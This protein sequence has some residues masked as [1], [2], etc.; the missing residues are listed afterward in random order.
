MQMENIF[1]SC[2]NH[3]I[4][5]LGF[6]PISGAQLRLCGRHDN[7]QLCHCHCCFEVKTLYMR[8]LQ[9]IATLPLPLVMVMVMVMKM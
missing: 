6:L 1:F 3:D 7:H 9:D 5:D 4:C 2:K 8:S